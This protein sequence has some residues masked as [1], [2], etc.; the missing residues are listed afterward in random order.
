MPLSGGASAAELLAGRGSRTPRTRP[1]FVPPFPY[2]LSFYRLWAYLIRYG[3]I[4]IETRPKP[5]LYRGPLYIHAS[6]DIQTERNCMQAD[7]EF[8]NAAW[9]VIRANL[10]GWEEMQHSCIVAV[11][12]LVDIIPTESAVE[13]GLNAGEELFGDYSPGRSAWLLK[14]VL[15]VD[16]PVFCKGSNGLWVPQR[17]V[18][19]QVDERLGGSAWRQPPQQSPLPVAVETREQVTVAASVED[20]QERSET[21]LGLFTDAPA[22]TS[23]QKP[24]K[25]RA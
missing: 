4:T 8:R 22:S 12:Q 1:A 11:A 18:C 16:P 5:Y 2:A 17:D 24:K 23:P 25:G 15:P 13:E 20:P 6:A 7:P 3:A 10:D 21:N 14:D 9:S 19:L